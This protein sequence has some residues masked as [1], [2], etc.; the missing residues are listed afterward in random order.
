MSVV[1]REIETFEAM[2]ESLEQGHFGKCVL[3]V[4]EQLIGTHDSFQDA[5]MDANR[6]F[7]RGP[8]LIRQVAGALPDRLS[9]AAVFGRE[10]A[11]G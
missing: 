8:Y 11:H 1:T 5:A 10:Y 3:I 6:Q 9:S 4:G 2:R 7:G